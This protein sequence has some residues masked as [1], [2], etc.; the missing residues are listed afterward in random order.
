[1]NGIKSGHTLAAELKTLRAS[2]FK[3][4]APVGKAGPEEAYHL[5]VRDAAWTAR[6]DRKEWRKILARTGPKK[7]RAGRP[8]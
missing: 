7:R 8:A 3:L 6:Y 1:M 5:G 4:Y 2:I